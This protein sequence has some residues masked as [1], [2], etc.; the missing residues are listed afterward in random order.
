LGLRGTKWRVAGEHCIMG[1][2]VTCRVI[3]ARRMRCARLIARMD[4]MRFMQKFWLEN[5]K[6]RDHSKDLRV[7]GKVMLGCILR[8]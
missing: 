1:S 8:K 6:G 3:K 5:L 4:E 2:F 7:V